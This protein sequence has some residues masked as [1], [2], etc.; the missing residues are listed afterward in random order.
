M[1][2]CACVRVDLHIHTRRHRPCAHAARGS[3]AGSDKQASCGRQC[4]HRDALV[5]DTR[6]RVRVPPP[7]IHLHT[8]LCAGYYGR[9]A[10]AT[11]ARGAERREGRR[12]RTCWVRRCCRSQLS[13]ASKVNATPEGKYTIDGAVA[14][15]FATFDDVMLVSGGR[16][17]FFGPR[18]EV[19]VCGTRVSVYADTRVCVLTRTRACRRA[20]TRRSCRTSLAWALRLRPPRQRRTSCRSAKDAAVQCLA[21][22]MQCRNACVACSFGVQRGFTCTQAE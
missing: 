1:Q 7:H 18:Q 10:A 11:V 13:R 15:V 19:R 20:H 3:A 22:D 16:L 14:Q 9:V 6:V 21:V 17:V 4:T 2:V 5:L 12:G 8:M